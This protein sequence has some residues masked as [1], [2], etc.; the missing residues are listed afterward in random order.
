MI[1]DSLNKVYANFDPLLP[2]PGHSELY[3]ERKKN[4]LSKIKWDLLNYNPITIPP[5]LLFSGHR[6]SGKSTE[7]NRLI[8]DEEM[9]ERYFIVHYSVREVLDIA[10]LDYTDLLLSVGAQVFAKA[11]DEKVKLRKRLLDELNR[12]RGTIPLM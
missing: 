4:P 1:A 10:G 9:K 7:L 12:W 5:K 3:V 11:I 2:L 6:G 8:A